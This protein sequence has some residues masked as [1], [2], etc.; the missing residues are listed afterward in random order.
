MALGSKTLTLSSA[1]GLFS[2]VISG[3]GGLTVAAGTETLS[4]VN[5]YTGATT[6]AAGGTLA[7]SGQG[8]VAASASVDAN[9]I[10]N[11]AAAD[12]GVTITSL[13][14]QGSV[15]LGSNTLTFAAANGTFSGTISGSGG[16]VLKSGSETLTGANTYTGGTSVLGGTLGIGNSSAV[17]TG[18]VS[19]AN[20]GGLAFTAASVDLSNAISVAG[21]NTLNVS[22]GA[23]ATLSGTIGDG[24]TS[25]G[26]VKTGAGTLTLTGAN[27]Y[28][29]GTTISEGTLVGNTTSLHGSI[30]DNAALVF[31]QT[32]DGTYADAISGTGS[33]TKTGAGTLTL[34]GANTYTG[35]TTISAGTLVGDTMSLK[36]DIADNAAL[37]FNQTEDG[38]YAGALSGSGSVTKTGAGTLTFT[39]A[40]TYTGG[41]TI[42]AGTL[43]GNTDSLHGDITNDAALKFVQLADGTFAGAVT[44]SGSVTKSGVGTL[45]LTGANTYTGGTTISAGTL[46]G[47]TTSLQGNITNDASLVFNQ[48]SNG[49]FAGIVTGSGS[50]T[51]DGAGILTMTGANSYTGGTIISAGTLVG[52]TTNLQGEISNNASLVFNQTSDG[53]FAGAVTGSGSMTKTG[54]GTLTLTGTLSNTGTTTVSEGTLQIGNG[55]T[56]GWAYGPIEID[57]ALVYDLSGFY[58]LPT[59]LS[60]SGSL[61][62]TGGGTAT[63][64][65]SAAYN[66]QINVENANLVLQNGSSANSAFVVGSGGVL[67]GTATIGSLVIDNGGTASPGYSPGTLTVAGNVRFA[68]GSVYLVD[69]YADGSHDLITAGGT[70]NISGGTVQVVAEAGYAASKATYTILTADGG[71]S[72][73]FDAIT[74]NYAYLTPTLSYDSN[75]IYLTLQR[76]EVNFADM[77]STPNAHAVANAAQS[78]GDGNAIYDALVNLTPEQADPAFNSLSGEAYASANTVLLQQSSYLREAVGSRVR[79]SLDP[80][81]APFGPYAATLAPGYDATVWSQAFGAWG[82]NAGDGNAASVSSSI[83]GFFSGIDG[84]LADNTRVGLIAGYSRSNFKSDGRSSSGS[85][86]NYD[87]GIYAGT[88]FDAFSLF[89]GASYTWHDIS[90]DRSVSFPGFAGAASA[91]YKAAT[92]QLFAEASYRFDLGKTFAG[93]VVLEPFANLAFVKL[94]TQH[95][96]ETGS[97][98]ALTGAGQSQSTLYSTFGARVSSTYELASG[99]VLVPYAALGWQHAF[100]NH[101]TGANLAFASGGTPF[102][103]EGVP[104]AKDTIIVSAGFD[105][106]FNDAVSATL[107]YNG[108]FASGVVDNSIKASINV[109]F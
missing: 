43:V 95:M 77:T 26:L 108:Q 88:R 58:D 4:G 70:A 99:A 14:G 52:D 5:T 41:T 30:A 38:T 75:N 54:T 48:T 107:T 64:G 90:V 9:G 57:S 102:T 37:V 3:S 40:N 59:S 89:G 60:G 81:K 53:T 50:V 83:G 87:L 105:Y 6:I 36:G 35:G 47:D 25:G 76:N 42:S 10:F 28:T 56:A 67:S 18:S 12:A 91:D 27:T 22:S 84:L 7:L 93:Q 31:N 15:V 82:R 44:G 78:L 19:L 24:A 21:T 46:V 45:T 16:L 80:S 39:G 20:G 74:A 51:K 86:D 63:Y 23:T 71:V 73:R 29:G 17:G 103:V 11:I 69:V 96:T 1:S 101:S 98:A 68:S 106:R 85:V 100:G 72:G 13:A 65:G 2:G 104:I 92:T 79:Q 33:V 55:G 94:D 34:T 49:I 66:G 109:R 8:S 62:I 32:E 97:A 61:T